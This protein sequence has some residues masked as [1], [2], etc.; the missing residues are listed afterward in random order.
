MFS[1]MATLLH[2]QDLACTEWEH[3]DGACFV[4]LNLLIG[5]CSGLLQG[6]CI[7]SF[8]ALGVGSTELWH[9][10]VDVP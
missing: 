10:G 5:T 9:S 8:L 2:F 7:A 4:P 6:G 1:T 3:V